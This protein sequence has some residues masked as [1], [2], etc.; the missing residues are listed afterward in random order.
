MTAPRRPPSP[1]LTGLLCRCPL[2]GLGPLFAGLLTVRQSCAACGGDLS[3]AFPGDGPAVFVILVLGAIIVPLALWL[4][5]R[6]APP[7]WVH[8]VLW[9]PLIAGGALALLRIFKATLIALQF[10]YRAGA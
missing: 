6:F 1:Y 9:G 3:K 2:C 10:R 8:V 7:A 5:M 4:E